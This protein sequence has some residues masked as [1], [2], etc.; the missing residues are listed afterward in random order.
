MNLNLDPR[1]RAA[2][3]DLLFVRDAGPLGGGSNLLVKEHP[4][5]I[6]LS[7]NEKSINKET[8]SARFVAS[9]EAVDSYGEIV[10]Q[11][12]NLARYKANPIVLYNHQRN[13]TTL[14]IGT[15]ET[16]M[17]GG[18]LECVITFASEKASPLAENVWNLVLEKV[19]RAV[20][21]GF[22]PLDMRLEM[23]NGEEVFVLDNNELY[24]I[25]V[26][27]IGANPEA[28]AKAK[29]LAREAAA[30]TRSNP[31][32][33]SRAESEPKM[34]PLQKLSDER[35]VQITDLKSA[36]T[37]AE[38][39]IADLTKE[40]DTAVT[41]VKELGDKVKSAEARVVTLD[42]S[43][44]SLVVLCAAVGFTLSGDEPREKQ[45]EKFVGDVIKSNKELTDKTIDAE[46]EALVGV[47][48]DKSEKEGLVELRKTNPKLF[49]KLMANRPANGVLA[50]AN[51]G[52]GVMGKDP[53]PAQTGAHAKAGSEDLSTMLDEKC[54]G[55]SGGEGTTDLG[56][57]LDD[58]E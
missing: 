48:I 2:I 53:Q 17:V 37:V 26:T 47:K 33:A 20:S 34:D 49:E 32:H 45:L 23:H 15:A 28:L 6:E 10:K 31:G 52:A 14:P 27:P 41:Q 21:V 13:G 19:L 55:A 16:E 40:R 42:G 38:K 7:L 44:A 12:W 50:V 9:T 36:V 8:R 24:E 5:V 4:A 1:V 54:D 22:R 51:K 46:V 30:A 58:A 18:K 3:L 43:F 25:S 35:L 11:N 56:A 29:A 57:M 39:T